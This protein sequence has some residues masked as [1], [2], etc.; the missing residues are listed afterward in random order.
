MSLRARMGL[1]AGV[2]VALAVIAVSLAAYLGERSELFNQIDQSLTRLGAEYASEAARL[3][4]AQ[5]GVGGGPGTGGGPAAFDGGRSG[6]AAGN[7]AQRF[8]GDCDGGLGING[9]PNSAFGGATGFVQI[10]TANGTVCR[11]T[12]ETQEIPVM[13]RARTIAS[14]GRGSF[15]TSMTVKR[16]SHPRCSSR[17]RQLSAR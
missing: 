9:P 7:G 2:A 8:V 11:G 5:Q 1:G 3:G 15:F 6:G 17:P 12:G 16:P 13:D 14:S 10:L 4:H